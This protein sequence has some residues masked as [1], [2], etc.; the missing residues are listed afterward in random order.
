M[1]DN[2]SADGLVA[3]VVDQ[4]RCIGS[5]TCE[6][7]EDQ[8]FLLDDDTNIAGVVGDGLLPHSRASVIVDRCP[9]SAISFDENTAEDPATACGP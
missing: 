4:D 6:M 7:L 3:M 1:S 5:G 9:A 2:A 8:I